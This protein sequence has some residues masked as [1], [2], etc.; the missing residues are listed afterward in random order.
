M[1]LAI[2]LKILLSKD[3]LSTAI[4]EILADEKKTELLK[5]DLFDTNPS[6]ITL[7]GK[8]VQSKVFLDFFWPLYSQL[9]GAS[10]GGKTSKIKNEDLAKMTNFIIGGIRDLRKLIGEEWHAKAVNSLLDYTE[11]A[12]KLEQPRK[13][14]EGN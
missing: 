13:I 12:K 14:T 5:G 1:K 4:K 8:K 6:S 2:N 10:G 11:I 3:K 9:V 7:Y